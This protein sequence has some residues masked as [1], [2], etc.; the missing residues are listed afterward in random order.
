MAPASYHGYAFAIIRVD[1]E[2]TQCQFRLR[3]IEAACLAR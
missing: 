3:R 1:E 2:L